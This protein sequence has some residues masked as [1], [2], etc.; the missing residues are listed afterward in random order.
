MPKL[1]LPTWTVSTVW[2]CQFV[3]YKVHEIHDELARVLAKAVKEL[4]HCWDASEEFTCQEEVL[5]SWYFWSG[6]RQVALRRRLPFFQD[7]HEQMVKSWSALQSGRI[8][9]LVQSLFSH[10]DGV[11]SHRYMSM[12]HIEVTAFMPFI[13]HTGHGPMRAVQALQGDSQPG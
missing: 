9:T 2:T 6:C 3:S 5:D 8:H 11:E 4:D 1:P 10:V 13:G 7:I 12:P